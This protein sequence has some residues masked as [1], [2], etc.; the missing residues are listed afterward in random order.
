MVPS[1]AHATARRSYTP[2]AVALHPCRP[3]RTLSGVRPAVAVQCR[4]CPSPGHLGCHGDQGCSHSHPCAAGQQGTSRHGAGPIGKHMYR[5]L[6][7]RRQ[8]LLVKGSS[9]NILSLCGQ[10]TAWMASMYLQY[11]VLLGWSLCFNLLFKWNNCSRS[12]T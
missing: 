8:Q 11:A 10:P 12:A 7:H 2:P 6:Q 9:H 1:A 4:C 5:W 3:L